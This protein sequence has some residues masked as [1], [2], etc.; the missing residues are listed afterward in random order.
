M[1]LEMIVD[2]LSRDKKIK[3]L[4]VWDNIPFTY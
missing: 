1:G 4:D 2:E 3:V